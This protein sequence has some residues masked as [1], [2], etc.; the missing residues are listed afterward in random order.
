MILKTI[1]I[2]LTIATSA[3][4][5]ASRPVIKEFSRTTS[6]G[7]S[8]AGFIGTIRVQTVTT[9]TDKLAQF[10]ADGKVHFLGLRNLRAA[11]FSA[12]AAKTNYWGTYTGYQVH[13][14]GYCIERNIS[15]QRASVSWRKSYPVRSVGASA[16]FWVGPVPV[17]VSGSVGFGVSANANISL[18]SSSVRIRGSASGWVSASASAG[19]GVPF[20]N[21]SIVSGFQLGKTTVT[22]SFEAGRNWKRGT[23]DVSLTPLSVSLSLAIKS[24]PATLYSLPIE[25]WS[26]QTSSYRLF[27]F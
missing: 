9:S 20:F 18:R 14:A 27:N 13:L 10:Y 19:I 3:V 8:N 15:S 1:T 6:H 17:T 24:G 23:V 22:P 11:E 5:T 12:H 16:G 2:G 4:A 25:N 26:T 21:V 7:N